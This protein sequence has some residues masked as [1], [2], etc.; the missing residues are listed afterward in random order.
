VLSSPPEGEV[1]RSWLP[2]QSLKRELTEL[3]PDNLVPMLDPCLGKFY[4]SPID[5][6]DPKYCI[7]FDNDRFQVYP[8]QKLARYFSFLDGPRA[9]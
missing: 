9:R 2:P 8:S 4:I 5:V 1:L 6:V 3:L 7:Y